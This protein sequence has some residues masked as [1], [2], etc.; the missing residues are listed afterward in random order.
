MTWGDAIK[1]ALPPLLIF[2][3]V[4]LV[5]AIVFRRMTKNPVTRR[6]EEHMDRVETLLAK[7]AESLEKKGP[8]PP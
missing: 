6:Y 7:I 1:V 2:G 8:P 4:M 3:V 5:F